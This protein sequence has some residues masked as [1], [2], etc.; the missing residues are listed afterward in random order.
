MAS[1]NVKRYSSTLVIIKVQI[2]IAMDVSIQPLDWIKL[3]MNNNKYWPGWEVAGIH[4]S[5][6][7]YTPFN[8]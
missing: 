7:R 8:R 5:I 1:K 3:K 6:N 2:K 4:W